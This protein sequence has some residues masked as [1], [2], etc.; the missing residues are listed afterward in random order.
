M[1]TAGVGGTDVA[2]FCTL[3]IP[4][5]VSQGSHIAMPISFLGINIKRNNTGQ[6]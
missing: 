2:L 6:F 3:L 4:G 1:F 5:E